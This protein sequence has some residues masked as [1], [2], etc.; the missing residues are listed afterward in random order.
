MSSVA[1]VCACSDGWFPFP[2]TC[3]TWKTHRLSPDRK[4]VFCHVEQLSVV[5]TRQKAKKRRICPLQFLCSNMLTGAPQN[6][7]ERESA[8]FPSF[9]DGAERRPRARLPRCGASSGGGGVQGPTAPAGEGSW[10]DW[11]IPTAKDCW[12]LC[13]AFA[14]ETTRERSHVKHTPSLDRKCTPRVATPTHTTDT[15]AY[16][17]C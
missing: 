15:P 7:C 17:S 1:R 14:Q 3:H 6:L 16:S 12:D 13:T 5:P 11:A 10:S 4:R 2:F 9:H 8:T